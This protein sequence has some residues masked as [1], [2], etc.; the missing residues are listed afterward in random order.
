MNKRKRISLYTLLGRAKSTNPREPLS[1]VTKRIFALS[2]MSE[3]IVIYPFYVIM[4]GERGDVSAA[5]VGML[6]AIWLIV[7]VVSEIPTGIIADKMSKKW[8]LVLGRVM[9]ILTFTIWLVA[10][11]FAGYLVGFV[12]WGVGEAFISGAFQAYLYESL[13]DTNKK[14]F[15]KIYSRSSAFTMFAYTAGGLLAFLIGPHYPLLLVLSI[16]VSMVSLW[17]TLSLPST[18]SKTEVEVEIRPKVLASALQ[19]IRGN[20]GLRRILVAAIRLLVLSAAI[21]AMCTKRFVI[22][23]HRSPIR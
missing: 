17:I 14:A 5:R 15:G 13:D 3:F 23:K 10:P 4:F 7:S 21:W 16:A 9:Q 8:S 11:N 1:S 2:F 12:V 19:A 22:S 6:L 20:P 18:H